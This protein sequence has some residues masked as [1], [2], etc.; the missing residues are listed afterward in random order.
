MKLI[1]ISDTHGEHDSLGK[2]SGDVLI[3]CGDIGIGSKPTIDQVLHLDHWFGAQDFK[4][5]M[6]IGGNHDFALQSSAQRNSSLFKNA[7]YLEDRAVAFGGL[8]FYGAPWTPELKDWAYYLNDTELRA[9][10]AKI[11]DETD[12][13]ITHTPPFG[14]LDKN[15]SGRSCGCITLRERVMQVQPRLHCF[16]HIHASAGTAVEQGTIF[17]NAAVVGRTYKIARPPIEINL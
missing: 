10:W 14:V 13:L 8:L 6:C 16:G 4:L 17:V 11:P 1:I 7:E 9:R 12:V 5:K 2:L 15:S 3:H